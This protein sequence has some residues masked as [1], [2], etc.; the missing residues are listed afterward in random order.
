MSKIER[1]KS[2]LESTVRPLI[3]AS[4]TEHWKS[5]LKVL[6][7]NPSILSFGKEFPVPVLV[8]LDGNDE[9][10]EE[11]IDLL[12]GKAKTSITPLIGSFLKLVIPRVLV[13][14]KEQVVQTP[15][16][17]K[18]DQEFA[19]LAAMEVSSEMKKHSKLI[20]ELLIQGAFSV[21]D[22]IAAGAYQALMEKRDMHI[23]STLD[24][25]EYEGMLVALVRIGLVEQKIQVSVCPSCSIYEFVVSPIRWSTE[26][27]S[28]CG[29]EWATQTS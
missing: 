17:P 1:E 8:G 9:E 12:M 24:D 16:G 11:S 2:D 23:E 5:A 14:A 15:E 22:L 6:Y 28:K 10:I 7:L 25:E 3:E 19:I 4:N 26:A 21:S 13:I 20:N 27:C 18:K 29:G